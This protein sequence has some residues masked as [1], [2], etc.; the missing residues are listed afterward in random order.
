MNSIH[1]GVAFVVGLGGGEFFFS[2]F[3]IFIYARDFRFC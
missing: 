1:P 2:L 3:G